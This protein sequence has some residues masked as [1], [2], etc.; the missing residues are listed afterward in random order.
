MEIMLVITYMDGDG[1]Q[2]LRLGSGLWKCG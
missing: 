1:A 2:H